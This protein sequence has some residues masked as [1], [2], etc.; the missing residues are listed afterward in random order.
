MEVPYWSSTLVKSA[1]FNKQ[2]GEWEVEIE[3]EG[4]PMT[5]KPKHLIF[6]TGMVRSAN[7]Q[8]DG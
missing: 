8:P 6:A 3:R 5:L 7:L 1:N 2:A 4:K